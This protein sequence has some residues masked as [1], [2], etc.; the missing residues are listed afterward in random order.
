MKL[1]WGKNIKDPVILL[2]TKW[3]MLEIFKSFGVYLYRKTIIALIFMQIWVFEQTKFMFS[4]CGNDGLILQSYKS[5]R[6]MTRFWCMIWGA[7]W[8]F[9][10]SYLHLFIMTMTFLSYDGSNLKT[11]TQIHFP[12][13]IMYQNIAVILLQLNY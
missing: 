7:K 9:K 10:P 4:F 11:Q 5:Q 1:F 12:P 13:K 6:I 8:G 3:S 2:P